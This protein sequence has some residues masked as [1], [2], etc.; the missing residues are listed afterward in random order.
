V[1][2][3]KLIAILGLYQGHIRAIHGATE[4]CRETRNKLIAPLTSPPEETRLEVAASS[5]EPKETY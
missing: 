4:T 5:L 3:N 2:R 1:T